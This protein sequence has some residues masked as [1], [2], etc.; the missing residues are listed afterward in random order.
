[1]KNKK[2]L[3]IMSD[4]D[5]YNFI[6]KCHRAEVSTNPVIFCKALRVSLLALGYDEEWVET[7][8]RET[9]E[10]EYK[11]DFEEYAATNGA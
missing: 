8:F 6:W 3:A 5:M 4:T 7:T 9:L 10:N 11:I 2:K 1:M